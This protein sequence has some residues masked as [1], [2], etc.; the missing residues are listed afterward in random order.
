MKT[1]GSGQDVEMCVSA[2]A[3]GVRMESG[4]VTM[5]LTPPMARLLSAQ[6]AAAADSADRMASAGVPRGPRL[7]KEGA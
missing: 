5:T 2:S 4:E 6:L 7:A 1:T 3:L